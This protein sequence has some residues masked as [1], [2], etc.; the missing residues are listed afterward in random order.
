MR[1]SV[2]ILLGASAGVL[3]SVLVW[4]LAQSRLQATFAQGA[5]DLSGRLSAG[6]TSLERAFSEGRAQVQTQV[7]VAV[8][9]QV[10]PAVDRQIRTTLAQYG[11]TPTNARAVTTQIDR[12]L[13]WTGA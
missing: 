2:A 11:I 8:T 3:A 9:Q 1:P 13:A 5:A 10:P 4:K 12:V 6:G 7:R